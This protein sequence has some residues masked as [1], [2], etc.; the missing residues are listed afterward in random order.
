ME[1]VR[2]GYDLMCGKSVVIC[3]LARNLG[4]NIQYTLGRINYLRSL[5]SMSSVVIYTNDNDDNT[6]EILL[7]KASTDFTVISESL[8]KRYHG[9]TTTKERYSDM[10]CYRNKYLDYIKENYR[11]YDYIIVLDTD[12]DGGY[13]WDGLA[14]SMSWI[15][16]LNCDAMASNGL[17]YKDIDGKLTRLMYDTLAF[18]RLNHSERHDNS[19]INLLCYHRGEPPMQVN[20]AFGGLC[21]YGPKLLELTYQNYDCDHV[22]IHKEMQVYLNPSALTLYSRGPYNV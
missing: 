20:S 1:R 19:E 9:S 10:A 15:H 16:E 4:S 8:G 6:S 5:F 3:G 13:S 14:N 2:L 12:L 21:V 17:I 18:R 11:S 7:G 22:T